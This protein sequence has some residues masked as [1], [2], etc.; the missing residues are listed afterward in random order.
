M[1]RGLTGV[2]LKFLCTL[3]R[4]ASDWISLSS[5]FRNLVF[6]ISAKRVWID[7][8]QPRSYPQLDK[9]A[10]TCLGAELL[11]QIRPAI[12]QAFFMVDIGGK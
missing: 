9:P 2:Y 8:A 5:S 12:F 7:G 3:L 6:M 11:L 4:S 10:R 1:F